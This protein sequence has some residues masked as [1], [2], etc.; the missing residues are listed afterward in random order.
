[1]TDDKARQHSRQVAL[2]SAAVVVGRAFSLKN[3]NAALHFSCAPN[4]SGSSGGTET[5]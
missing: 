1:M 5:S 4:S 3:K 2:L